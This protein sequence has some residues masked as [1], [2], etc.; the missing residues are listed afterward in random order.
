MKTKNKL[1]LILI[2]LCLSSVVSAAAPS[3]IYGETG[4][5]GWT[6][7]PPNPGETDVISY[8]G[9]FWITPPYYGNSCFAEA[10]LG[11]TPM[12]SVDSTNRIIELWFQGPAPTQCILIYQ[13][14]CGLQGNFGPLTSG[15]WTFRCTNP[16]LAFEIQFTVGGAIGGTTYYVDQD[17]P[18]PFHNG[19]SWKWAFTN[20]QDALD[21]AIAGDTI[22]VAEGTHKPDQ[23]SSVTPG[24]RTASFQLKNGVSLIGSHAGYGHTDPDARDFETYATVL[25]GD[26]NGDDSWGILYKSENSYHVVSATGCMSCDAVLDG[27]IITAGQADGPTPYDTGGGVYIDGTNPMLKNC[28]ISSNNASFGGGIASV[29][30]GSPYILNCKII[31]NSAQFFG[32]G[33]Y[34]YDN[35]INLVNCL[36]TGNS[37]SL[38]VYIGGSAIYNFDGSITLI[39]CTVTKNLATNGMV[40]TSFVSQLPASNFLNI[41]N[42]ILYNGINGILTNHIS[43]VFVLHTCI[44]G[45][46]PA[47]TGN[48]STDP[49]F[50]NSG[51]YHLQPG[52]P[53]IDAGDNSLLPND[54]GDLDKDGNI[55]EL[56]S[57]ALDFV[58]RIL[59]GTV[60]MGAYE[61]AGTTPPWEPGSGSE[62][63]IDVP[64]PPPAF[65]ISLE[66]VEV[67]LT[68]LMNFKGILTVEIHATSAA[69]GTWNAWFDPDP[70]VVGPGMVTVTVKISADNV[71]L[72]QLPAGTTQQLAVLSVLVQPAP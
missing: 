36:I 34:C 24:D 27:F 1:L 63:F 38:S 40:I 37:A 48:I 33:L 42:C 45:G 19:A 39:N 5:S 32:G 4:P 23:G 66:E 41:Y 26:L 9:P 49:M 18:G 62:I 68:F 58:A 8:S 51:D 35:N 7:V 59:G 16:S 64:S 3:W 69:G 53:C 55:I 67:E 17:A 57:V 54:I 44:Q 10:D 11:G 15:N 28:I 25:S 43:T 46:W 52:S 61:H 12:I 65:P 60:D 70:G 20:L 72:S 30:G 29:N 71:D 6:I 50:V 56:L 31:D 14:V 2:S 22:L 21:V 47:G 13:P